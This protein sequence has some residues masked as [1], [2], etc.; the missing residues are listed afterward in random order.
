MLSI[1]TSKP[2][3]NLKL[4][5]KGKRKEEQNVKLIALNKKAQKM[6]DMGIPISGIYQ[7]TNL[8][9]N[10]IY[11]G[12]TVNFRKRLSDYNTAD[13]S[14]TTR[15]IIAAIKQYGQDNFIIELIEQCDEKDLNEREQYY[16]ES[17][18]SY[19]EGVGYNTLRGIY[20]QPDPYL[21]RK[22]KSE[23]HI[24]LKESPDTKRKKSNYI[25][26]VGNDKFI[27]ADSGKL[28]GNYVGATK[29]YIKNC[30]RQPSR[31]KDY[32][33]FYDDYSKRQEIKKK[34]LSKRSIRN[35]EYMEILD[36]LDECENESVETMYS[37]I[38]SKY[39]CIYRLKY[40]N[41]NSNGELFL[42]KYTLNDIIS[43]HIDEK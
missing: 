25:I 11:I 26:A 42:T 43:D 1:F 28:F 15:S 37:K 10:E 34:M 13:R 29:D 19:V 7:I 21:S 38:T 17:F 27:I 5:T 35:K 14:P 36:L 12:Q 30:L 20:H 9:T 18:K 3:P 39:N 40:E 23:G 8:L 6:W 32:N 2:N 16:I 33:L 24:G 22:H 31:I 41:T 4:T